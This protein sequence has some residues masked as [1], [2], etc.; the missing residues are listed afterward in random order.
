M[1]SKV[2]S[3]PYISSFCMELSLV[4]KAGISLDEGLS[5]L[6][7]D[8][9]DKQLKAMLQNLF[10]KADSGVALHVAMSESQRFP[11]YVVDMVAIGEKTGRTETVLKALSEHYDR[12]EQISRSIKNAVVY[13]AVLMIMLLLVIIILITRVLPIFNDVFNQLGAQMS[14]VALSIMNF[15]SALSK[16]SF[17]IFG[18]IAVIA[19]IAF[20]I[21]LVPAWR[22]KVVGLYSKMTASRG[23][24]KKIAS[25]RFAS[26]MAMT[27]ASGLD[28]DESLNMVERI[29]DNSSMK[30][31]IENCRKLMSEEEPFAEA[32]SKSEIFSSL[33]CR[34]LSVGFKTGTADS[35]MSEIARRSESDVDENIER[36]INRVE[37]TLV[38]IMSLIV[39]LILLSVMLPL[40]GIMTTIG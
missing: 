30:A 15:G 37:P 16:Y 20:I 2:L 23:I 25:A 35:V 28:T 13:P 11:K 31:K 17:I 3:G 32:I 6:Q 7:E 33:Y 10:E 21:S 5:M 9:S 29:T 18:V 24:N 34:M 39:G 27:L 22:L 1:S 8:E 14:P 4:M 12:Q 36:V 19:L 38:I 26:A 40:M